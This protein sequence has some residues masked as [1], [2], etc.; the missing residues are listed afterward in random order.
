MY[1]FQRFERNNSRLGN[2]ISI[3]KSYEIGLPLSFYEQNK[4]FNYKYTVLFYDS[5]KNAIGIQFTNDKSQKGILS[6]SRASKGGGARISVASFFKA[7]GIDP[8]TCAGR[9]EWVKYEDP[10]VGSLFVIDL[11]KR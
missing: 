9:Y 6:V 11:G 1:N 10:H 3:I 8:I 7:N 2:K 4:L 5:L